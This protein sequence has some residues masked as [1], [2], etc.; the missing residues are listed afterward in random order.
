MCSTSAFA[1]ALWLQRELELVVLI[2]LFQV[3]GVYQIGDE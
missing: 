2:R 1:Q 3:H